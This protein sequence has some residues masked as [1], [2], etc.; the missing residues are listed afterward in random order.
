MDLKELLGEDL[1]NQ[2]IE[3]AGD[4]KLAVVNDGNWL[5][6]EKFNEKN[7][8]VKDLKAE[9][10]QRDEQIGQLKTSVKGN[11]ELE[12]KIAGLQK[13]NDDWE[14]KYKETQLNTAIKLAAKGAKD[15]NDVLAFIKKDGLELQ[16]DGAVKGLDD[17]LKA[18]KESKSYLFEEPGLKGRMPN[19]DPTP[20]ANQTNLQTEYEKAVSTGNMP[21]AISIK[22]R[23]FQGEE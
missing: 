3:K 14:V 6:K 11:E 4:K 10:K 2:V 22:N 17:A 16:D 8:E 23:I 18:L 13:T 15:A 9:L 7:E 21:L 12:A 20:P 19:N 1:Y 5:P